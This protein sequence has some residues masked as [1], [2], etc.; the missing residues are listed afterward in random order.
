MNDEATRKFLQALKRLLTFVQRAHPA[1]PSRCVEFGGVG[2]ADKAALLA[3]EAAGT[4]P[5]TL[6]LPAPPSFMDDKNRE[7]A[8]PARWDAIL[9]QSAVY[10][11]KEEERERAKKARQG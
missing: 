9:K 6:A 1:D 11:E 5:A 7:V 3:A 2:G 4:G 8:V 10:R